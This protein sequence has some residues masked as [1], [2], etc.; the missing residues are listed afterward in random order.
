M[1]CFCSWGMEYAEIEKYASREMISA[2]EADVATAD[3]AEIAV[4]ENRYLGVVMPEPSQL[5]PNCPHDI[6]YGS[7][8]SRFAVF[9]DA[10]IGVRYAWK[11]YDWLHSV[12]DNIKK[13]H[14]QTPLDF[15]VQLGDNIDDGY[16]STYKQ[17]YDTYLEEIKR[18]EICDHE[19]PID[20]AKN[21]KI[22]NYEMQGNHDTSPDT[23]FFKQKLWYTENQ[24][25][26]KV[27]YVSFFASYGGYPLVNYRVAGNYSSYRSYG[28]ISD[29]TI[30]FVEESVTEAERNGA[31]YVVLFCHYGIS[32]DVG[33]P[34]LPETGL[35]KLANICKKHRIKL[36]FNGH[37]HDRDFSH[38]MYD[39][40]HDFDVSMLHDKYAVVEIYENICKVIIYETEGQTICRE[41]F[42]Q[43]V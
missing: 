26:E 7:F 17:D 20:G 22:P 21:G 10:H 43:L 19:K 29:E 3:G 8:L 9:A 30:A 5:P 38:R 32:Q 6:P 23:R 18:L 27:G 15:I 28:W 24:N 1:M 41:E 4:T 40:I 11:N 35:G 39:E 34:I 25:G 13:I 31:K 36:Y 16:P 33:A 2:D 12:F 37:E 14:T 42:V